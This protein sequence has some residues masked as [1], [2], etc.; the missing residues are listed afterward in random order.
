MKDKLN[1]QLSALV[2]DELT[3][4]EQELLIRQIGRDPELLQRLSRYQLISDAMQNHL[5]ETVDPAFSRRVHGALRQEPAGRG[6]GQAASL[7]GRWLR[8]VAGV[9]VAASVAVVAVTAL[10]TSREET[11]VQPAAVASVPAESEYKR[12]QDSAL[13]AVP[14]SGPG[15]DSSQLDVYL[16]NH[17]EYA[18]SRGMR[19]MLPYVRIVG[20]DMKRD[21]RE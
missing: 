11:T 19:G 12:A 1:E 2:D 10:Q 15:I 14:D 4:S 13:A 17:N 18:A 5:P 8:P 16:V 7:T 20:H 3:G 9:A 21:I 6:D